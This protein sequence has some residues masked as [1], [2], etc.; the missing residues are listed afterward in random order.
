VKLHL[1]WTFGKVLYLLAAI[2]GGVLVEAALDTLFAITAFR[3]TV[4]LTWFEWMDSMIGTFGNYPL[5]ILPVS[6]R[7]LLTFV[8][9]IG[10]IA[11]LPAAVLT[12]RVAGSGV[13]AWLAYCSPAAGL[14]LYL[15]A[16]L[17][18]VWALRRYESVGG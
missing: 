6:P 5:N 10:F 3:Y 17:A 9:P 12:G 1:A 11:Y 14:L 7:A 16:R 2:A 4:G 15:G 13:P 8:L 18:W